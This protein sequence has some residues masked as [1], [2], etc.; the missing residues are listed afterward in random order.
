MKVFC[1]V[2]TNVGDNECLGEQEYIP[3]GPSD[4]LNA[5]TPL[6]GIDFDLQKS[7]ATSR[8]T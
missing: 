1:V 5:G 3:F 7:A 8:E 2:R 6:E 4:V